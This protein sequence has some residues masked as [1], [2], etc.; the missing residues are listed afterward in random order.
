[1][2]SPR[3]IY[4]LC[5]KLF[6]NTINVDVGSPMAQN[7][8]ALVAEYSVKLR[9]IPI[10]GSMHVKESIYLYSRLEQFMVQ[11]LMHIINEHYNLVSMLVKK[12][13]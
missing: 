8:A 3:I 4:F 11:N 1:M 7:A 6:T 5:L 9:S 10:C 12:P 2:V 13:P